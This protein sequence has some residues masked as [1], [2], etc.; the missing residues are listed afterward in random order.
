VST[1]LR[2]ILAVA[3]G[4][5]A[6]VVAGCESTSPDREMRMT[7]G[8][9][10]YC[11]GAG[12]GGLMNWAGGLKR[13]LLD[14]GY[15]GAGEIF[16]WNTGLGVVADQDASVEYKR[17]KAGEMAQKAAA[18]V[19]QHPGA[20]VSFIGLSAGTAVLVFALEEMPAGAQVD[21]AVLCGASVS[22]TYDLTRALRNL[23]GKM[24]VFTSEQD[25]VLGFLVPMAGTA[26][27]AGG[28]VAA[29]G[30]RGFR[31]PYAASPETRR[32]YAKVVTI[33][34][35]PEFAELGYA[36]GH[37]DVLSPRFVAAYMAPRLVAQV[38]R[39]PA[40]LAST[41]GK[42]RNPDYERWAKFG[43]GSCLVVEGYQERGGKRAPLRLKATL[44]SKS[45]DRLLVEREFYLTDQDAT[46]PAQVHSLIAEAWIDPRYHPTTDPR[47]KLADLP[48]KRIT[49]KGRTLTCLGRSIDADGS[50]PDWGS[51]LTATAYRCPELPGGLAEVE[52]ESHFEGEPFKFEGR[53]VD[54]K[55]V[56]E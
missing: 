9:V 11:D 24:Y 18:Y 27:R 19:R 51:D 42:V 23:N 39:A 29:A 46:L 52:L 30:L 41:A 48:A 55:I 36:G 31:V 5:C 37:T 26:D 34:W 50:Y 6:F 53:V 56:G 2:R 35:R 40:A 49:V 3:T 25:A 13:G 12:G 45:P 8:Y 47:S 1:E 16:R 7:R 21:N 20:P 17:G 44:Q 4:L 10:Y 32:Q 22:S 28:E 38:G 43:V 15:P 33:P 54:F 14:G